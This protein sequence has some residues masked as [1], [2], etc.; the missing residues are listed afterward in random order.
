MHFTNGEPRQKITF[1]TDTGTLN[2]KSW[3]T[4]WLH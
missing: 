3:L 1:L 2:N 4:Y